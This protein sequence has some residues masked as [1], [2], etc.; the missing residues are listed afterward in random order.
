MKATTVFPALLVL[1]LGSQA[2]AVAMSFTQC[3]GVV[4]AEGVRCV[5]ESGTDGQAGAVYRYNNI[6]PGIDGLLTV[7]SLNNGATLLFTDGVGVGGAFG[8][9]DIIIEIAGTPSQTPYGSFTLQFVDSNTTTPHVIDVLQMISYDIDTSDFDLYSDTLWV[10]NGVAV[11]LPNPTYL[12]NTAGSGAFAGN[13]EIQLQSTYWGVM[14]VG[15]SDDDCAD[16]ECQQLVTVNLDYTNVS[17]L[18]WLWG[19]EGSH[20]GSEGRAMFLS[21][22]AI[23]APEP[24]TA[25]LLLAGAAAAALRIRRGSR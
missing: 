25:L 4:L 23:F 10:P 22:N 19:M 12:Q 11:S 15:R 7:N 18:S 21:G 14:S 2:H 16:P 8:G 17:S 9:D 5:P 1:A 3:G 13:Q 6:A 24:S 20:A